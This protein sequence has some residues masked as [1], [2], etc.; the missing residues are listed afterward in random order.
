MHD[1]TSSSKVSICKG[2]VWKCFILDPSL[3]FSSLNLIESKS[4]VTVLI[5]F[6][7]RILYCRTLLGASFYFDRQVQS[8]WENLCLSVWRPLSRLHLEVITL[9]C[10]SRSIL[11][12]K[13]IPFPWPTRSRHP[14]AGQHISLRPVATL[15]LLPTGHSA[16]VPGNQTDLAWLIFFANCRGDHA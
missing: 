2:M 7:S 13:S 1:R 4:M 6:G 15:L 12:K 10:V 11:N 5:T 3:S 16:S 8:P 14:Q 9:Y